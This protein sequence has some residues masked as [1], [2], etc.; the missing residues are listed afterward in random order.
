MAP[1]YRVRIPEESVETF[2]KLINHMPDWQIIKVDEAVREWRKSLA[3]KG[4]KATAAKLT[5][6]Q[7]SASARKASNARWHPHQPKS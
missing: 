3:S 7:R 6:E 1:E 5:P 2:E 4:G